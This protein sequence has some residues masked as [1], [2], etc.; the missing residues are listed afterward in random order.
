MALTLDKSRTM[1]ADANLPKSYW[2]EALN[3]ATLLHNLSPSCSIATTPSEAYTGMK[4][5]VSRLHIF[6]CT[7]HVHVPEKSW[8]KLS[9][10]SLPYT[11]LGFSHQCSAFHLI[12]HPSQ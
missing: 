3:Y 5:D 10:H 9:T 4:L 6:G 2:L 1:L 11:F 8:D 7:A 12:H